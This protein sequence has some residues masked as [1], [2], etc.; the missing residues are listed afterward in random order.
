M[1]LINLLLDAP[2]LAFL[3]DIVK[4]LKMRV[5]PMHGLRCPADR[6]VSVSPFPDKSDI[7][8]QTPNGWRDRLTWSLESSV[9]SAGTSSG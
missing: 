5:W 1:A 3:R 4:L 9:R 2:R 7:S 6:Q 8:S